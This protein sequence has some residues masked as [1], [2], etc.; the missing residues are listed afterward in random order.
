MQ[1]TIIIAKVFVGSAKKELVIDIP[2]T[3]VMQVC[4]ATNVLLKYNWHLNSI[5]NKTAV[6]LELQSVKRYWRHAAHVADELSHLQDFL[7]ALA[8]FVNKTCGN[9]DQKMQ[10]DK[11]LRFR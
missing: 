7:L 4:N 6:D 3:K 1:N 5:D 11:R 2:D 8:M 10:L 9:Y